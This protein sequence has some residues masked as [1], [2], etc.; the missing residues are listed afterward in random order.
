ML[1]EKD[2]VSKL[3]LRLSFEA[4]L[5]EIILCLDSALHVNSIFGKP[6]R[7]FPKMLLVVRLQ[8]W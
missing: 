8:D 7:K 1:L 5:K 3:N 4:H 6:I 2:S